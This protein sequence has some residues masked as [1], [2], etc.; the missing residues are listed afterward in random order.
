MVRIPSG[1]FDMG[2]PPNEPDSIDMERPVHRVDVRAFALGRYDVTRQEFAA[3]VRITHRVVPKGCYYSGRHVPALDPIGSWSSLG[4]SQTGRDPVV[5]VTW[6][7]AHD[8]AA[9]LSRRTGRNYRL[10]TE[11]EWEYAARAGSRTTYYWGDRVER[12]KVNYGPEKGFGSGLAVGGDRWVNTSPAGAFPANRFGLYDMSGNVL[13]MVEDCLS[14]SYA[15]T[16]TDGSAYTSNVPL[17]LTGDL[18]DLEGH[19]SCEFRML[20][21]GDWGDPP[22]QLRSAFRNFLP[23]PDSTLETYRSGGVGFRVARDLSH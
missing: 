10:P 11:A 21:G 17:H 20:R 8:Y 14:A 4:F 9:W 15:V 18:A 3:F 7:D 1:H 22:G 6:T 16:P 12:S 23:G 2:A 5:C 13:Q 19:L